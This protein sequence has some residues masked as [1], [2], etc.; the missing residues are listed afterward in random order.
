MAQTKKVTSGTTTTTTTAAAAATPAAAATAPAPAPAPAA[1]PAAPAPAPAAAPSTN[2]E[3][4][5][6]SNLW[7]ET[8]PAQDNTTMVE[9][10]SNVFHQHK[11]RLQGAVRASHQS[12]LFLNK[13]KEKKEAGQYPD[14]SHTLPHLINQY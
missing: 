7:E 13:M 9:W 11:K 4:E 5:W 3:Q 2:A 1:A 10:L 12:Q 14:V 8:A 6:L